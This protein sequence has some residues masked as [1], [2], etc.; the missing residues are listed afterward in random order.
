MLQTTDI[1]LPTQTTEKIFH[2]AIFLIVYHT[3]IDLETLTHYAKIDLKT[4][5]KKNHKKCIK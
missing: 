2:E 5:T 4:L 1:F 3:K